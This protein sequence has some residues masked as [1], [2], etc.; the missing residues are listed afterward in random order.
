MNRL[1]SLLIIIVVGLIPFPFLSVY[2]QAMQDPD[3]D[4][5]SPNNYDHVPMGDLSVHGTSSDDAA[6]FCE[7]GV[8]L[9]KD[10]PY[11][12]ATALGEGGQD[13]Y[14]E[15]SYTITPSYTNIEEGLNEIASRIVCYENGVN[16]SSWSTVNVTGD[17]SLHQPGSNLTQG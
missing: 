3:I 16:A 1:T 6:S 15:W 9:N 10:T 8:I 14:S 13:D 2:A 7:V 12:N 5:T 4:I 11:Q 17:P